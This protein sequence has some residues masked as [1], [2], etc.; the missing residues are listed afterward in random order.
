MQRMHTRSPVGKM[1]RTSL[2]A[3]AEDLDRL[4][5]IAEDND[6][7][8]SAELRRLIRTRIENVDAEKVGAP[9]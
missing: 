8:L 1:R 9:A 5:E 4:R 2:V 3:P 7:T 6:R